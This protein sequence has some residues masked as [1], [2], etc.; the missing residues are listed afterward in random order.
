MAEP[1]VE[2]LDVERIVVDAHQALT[3]EQELREVADAA[4]RLE[5]A[6]ADVGAELLQDPPVQ[7]ARAAHALQH[8]VA[9]MGREAIVEERGSKQRP[10]AENASVEADL[11]LAFGDA[12]HV[13]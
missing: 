5:H 9:V 1:P 7:P 6:I 2:H 11:L 13:R 12:L 10:F 4:A 8:V 3:I